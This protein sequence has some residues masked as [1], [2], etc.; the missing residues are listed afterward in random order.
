LDFQAEAPL[1]A[2]LEESRLD[3]QFVISRR[4]NEPRASATETLQRQMCKEAHVSV[5]PSLE[6]VFDA[7]V[8]KA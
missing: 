6:L 1:Q 2:N 5:W 7:S 3:G 8:D 4:C